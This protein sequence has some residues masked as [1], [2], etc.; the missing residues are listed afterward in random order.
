M[1]ERH[2]NA[3]PHIISVGVGAMMRRTRRGGGGGIIRQ[4]D[5]YRTLDYEL[6]LNY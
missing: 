1:L 6:G 4:Q 3:D 2:N 5:Y